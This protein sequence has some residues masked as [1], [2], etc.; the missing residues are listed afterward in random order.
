YVDYATRTIAAQDG[1]VDVRVVLRR[2][3]NVRGAQLDHPPIQFVD[4]MNH[5]GL[6]RPEDF[7]GKTTWRTRLRMKALAVVEQVDIANQI[8]FRI[9][10]RDPDHVRIEYFANLVADQIVDRLHLQLRGQTFLHAVDDRQLGVA[11]LGFL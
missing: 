3:A 7:L 2:A 5:D 11:L 10:Q 1:D 9:K 8:G 4:G 6:P